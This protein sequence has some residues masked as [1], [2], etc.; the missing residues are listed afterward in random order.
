M[1]DL[2]PLCHEAAPG[3]ISSRSF[4]PPSTFSNH[5][6]SVKRFFST[7]FPL[8]FLPHRGFE[9]DESRS[10]SCDPLVCEGSRSLLSL[11][12]APYLHYYYTHS[13]LLLILL[14]LSSSNS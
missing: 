11:R 14:H 4:R 3:Y 9:L 5:H 13:V 12:R 2:V 7:L 1:A 8:H 10:L 6:T